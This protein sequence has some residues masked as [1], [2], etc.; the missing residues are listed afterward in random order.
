MTENSFT[1]CVELL[2]G[3]D[4]QGLAPIYKEY[5]KLVYSAALSV[6][7]K[8]D[9][10]EDILSEFFLRFKKAAEVYRAGTGHK[11]WLV[12]S[13]RNLAVDYLRKNRRD[14]PSSGEKRL[15]ESLDEADSEESVTGKVTAE[16]M[17]ACLNEA[18]RETVNLKVYC[19]FTLSEIAGIM[20]VPLGTAA[21]RYNSGINKLRK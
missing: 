3:G 11:K 1:E 18:E 12:I 17:L 4:M 10:A 19:G 9:M 16:E 20:H 14:I 21:W 8:A 13:A 6:C 5:G 15:E 7:G 2:K